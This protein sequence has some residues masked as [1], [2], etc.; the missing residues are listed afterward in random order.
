MIDNLY[1]SL[2]ISTKEASVVYKSFAAFGYNIGWDITTA[3]IPEKVVY[4]EMSFTVVRISCRCP[5][6]SIEIPNSVTSI[7]DRAFEHCTGLTS[8]TCDAVTPPTLGDEV[9]FYVHK[10]IPLY[11]PE[12][13]IDIYKSADQWQD[14]TNIQTI[15]KSP[16]SIDN[17][18]SSSSNP[19]P[20]TMKVIKDNQ[21]LILTDDTRTYTLTGQRVK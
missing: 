3:N 14:F 13:S 9:F 4:D 7:G 5:L 19:L 8:I 2:N 6:S 16:T 18:V 1:Y 15:N 20:I 10:N 11:V 12:E 17:T 21:I